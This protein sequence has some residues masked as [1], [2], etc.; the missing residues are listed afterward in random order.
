MKNYPHPIIAKEGWPYLGA[1]LLVAIGVTWC[2]G[3][4][5]VP[6]AIVDFFLLPFFPAPPPE[7]PQGKGAVLC[8]SYGSV[9]VVGKPV[10]PY[11]GGVKAPKISVFMN[12]F[13]VHS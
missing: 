1:S 10:G 12:V 8:P 6:F 11:R 5:P 7:T 4:R 13:N 2:C 3:W 9:L